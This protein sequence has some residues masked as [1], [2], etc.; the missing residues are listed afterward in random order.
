M[1]KLVVRDAVEA[2]APAVVPLLG[3]DP[4]IDPV[5][6]ARLEAVWRWLYFSN[7]HRARKVLLGVD[8]TGA[9]VGHAAL[10]P[11]AYRVKGEERIGGFQCQ[12]AVRE[13]VRSTGLFLRLTRKIL[14]EYRQAGFD[15]VY[16]LVTRPAVREGYLAL[17]FQSVGKVPVV[18]RPI[19]LLPIVE[20]ISGRGALIRP[21]APLLR[22]ADDALRL[23]VP[24]RRQSIQV[25]RVA[26]LDAEQIAALSV[27]YEGLA[28]VA[29]RN[30]AIVRWRFTASARSEYRI[31]LATVD[32]RVT[33]MMVLRT[34][35][36]KGLPTLT[37]VDLVSANDAVAL[38]LLSE[39]ERIGRDEGAALLA[40]LLPRHGRFRRAYRRIGFMETPEF[41]TLVV[42]NR[43]GTTPAVVP[44]AFE[45]W[46]LSFFEHDFV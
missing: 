37:V 3:S 40:A 16:S 7:P 17:G 34:T 32:G 41:F 46:H 22:V 4:E 8:E 30:E 39:A 15:F 23:L 45:D 19:H 14:A 10:L 5:E 2:D 38:A 44:L 26:A 18:A 31:F 20:K 6:H 12:L 21:L 35:P 29:L 33:G 24:R 13:D 28:C 9:I 1:G 27:G 42:H 11:F 36:M 43:G 25:T